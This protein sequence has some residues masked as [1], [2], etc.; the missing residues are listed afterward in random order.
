MKILIKISFLMVIINSNCKVFHDNTEI[1]NNYKSSKREIFGKPL[2]EFEIQ[3]PFSYNFNTTIDSFVKNYSSKLVISEGFSDRNFSKSTN[4]LIP[5]KKYKV[6]IIPI[7]DTISSENCINYIKSQNAILVNAQGLILIYQLKLNKMIFDSWI[8]SFDNKSNLY[9]T[10]TPNYA[11]FWVPIL[12]CNIKSLPTYLGYY[13]F[14][15]TWYNVN[16]NY[17]FYSLLVVN[18]IEETTK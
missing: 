10:S 5:G 3:V 7:N 11:E 9:N 13:E 14:N 18:E 15:N 8:L 12:G 1:K 16:Q 4:S 17:G 2:A 6:K